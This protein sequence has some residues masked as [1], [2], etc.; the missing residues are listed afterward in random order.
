MVKYT[1]PKIMFD[2]EEPQPVENNKVS[3]D[4]IN[5]QRVL[6]VNSRGSKRRHKFISRDLISIMAHAKGHSKIE[7]DKD[8]KEQIQKRCDKAKCENYMFFEV[9]KNFQYLWVGKSP[10]GPCAY[11]HVVDYL[12]LDKSKYTGN[13]MIA[14]RSL[15][16]FGA[17]F[18]I[19]PEYVVLKDLL[20]DSLNVPKNYPRTFPYL[21]KVISFELIDG[22]IYVRMFQIKENSSMKEGVELIEAGPRMTLQLIKICSGVVGG[23]LL[24]EN[25]DYKEPQQRLIEKKQLKIQKKIKKLDSK[26]KQEVQWENVDEEEDGNGE[27]ANANDEFDEESDE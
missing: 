16:S 20:V 1:E 12:P 11:L 2:S 21:E 19:N 17:E 24:Y 13:F 4:F 15:L 14:S 3:P 25:P 26:D 6:V 22:I 27:F 23:D 10:S 18:D 8:I 7:I 9:K 5:R